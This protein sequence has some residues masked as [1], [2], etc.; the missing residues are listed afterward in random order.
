M[1]LRRACPL[2]IGLLAV[3]VARTRVRLANTESELREARAE[4]LAATAMTHP[5]LGDPQPHGEP[6]VTAT[7]VAAGVVGSV[8]DLATEWEQAV[9]PSDS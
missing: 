6:G 1:A 8:Q 7:R 5:P 2:L 9:P 4:A 3:E